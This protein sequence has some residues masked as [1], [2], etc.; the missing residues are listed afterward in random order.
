MVVTATATAYLGDA[1]MY[2]LVSELQGKE[3]YVRHARNM[4]LPLLLGDCAALKAV[5]KTKGVV[6][7]V[8][9]LP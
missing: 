7:S 2:N 6:A 8:A 3:A 1:R 5:D 4:V 9:I